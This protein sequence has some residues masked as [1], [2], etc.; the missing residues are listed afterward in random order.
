MGSDL[1]SFEPCSEFPG[2]KAEPSAGGGF[3]M[4]VAVVAVWAWV[5]LY[6]GYW[7]GTKPLD[8]WTALTERSV[9]FPLCYDRLIVPF[10]ERYHAWRYPLHN[11]AMYG[12]A[13]PLPGLVA[14]GH[15]VGALDM[16]SLTA[17]EYAVF[18]RRPDC[19]KALLA[20][21]APTEVKNLHDA[22]PLMHAVS[23]RLSNLYLP[24][25]E[26]GARL[27]AICAGGLTPLH[28][29]AELGLLDA[30]Q[31]L[32]ASGTT[33]DVTDAAG[34]TPLEYAAREGRTAVVIE[35]AQRGASTQ[36]NVPIREPLIQVYLILCAKTG[37]PRK[38]AQALAEESLQGVLRLF[39]DRWYRPAE[40]PLDQK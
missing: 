8:V 31:Q 14:G 27:D 33:L 21:G 25:L 20:A 10:V 37:D 13:E 19:A 18:F 35:L 6:P 3:L 17:L 2:P 16:V 9:G 36:T 24:L 40:F 12:R 7:H 28:R 29:A 39:R 11:A 38:A 23:W 1:Y 30:I 5:F 32:P 4:K 15:V 26:N 22:T 34:L